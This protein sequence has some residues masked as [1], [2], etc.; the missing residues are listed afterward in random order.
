MSFLRSLRSPSEATSAIKQR[1]FGI[2]AW[3]QGLPYS[4]D[5]D[6]LKAVREGYER[7]VWVFRCVNAYAESWEWLRILQRQGRRDIGEEVNDPHDIVSLLNAF[8]NDYEEANIFRKRLTG[9]VLLSKKGAFV[10]LIPTRD[11]GG[12][13][14]NGIAGLHILPNEYTSVVPGSGGRFLD[15]FE[16]DIP[17]SRKVRLPPERVVWVRNG[18]PTDP[19]SSETPLQ[20]AGLAVDT[21]FLA[22]LYNRNFIRNDGRPGMILFVRGE[23]SDDDADELEA[24]ANGGV[25]GRISV[26]ESTVDGPD[27]T[28]PGGGVDVVELAKALS[29]MQYEGLWK[30]TKEEILAAHACPESVALGNASGRTF[31]NADAERLIWYRGPVRSHV[32]RVLA[33]FDRLD[34]DPRRFLAAD[35]STIP[36]IQEAELERRKVGLDELKGTGITRE[37][38]RTDYANRDPVPADGVYLVPANVLPT[39]AGAEP[40]AEAE[41]LMPVADEPLAEQVRAA[42][43]DRSED[44][45]LAPPPDDSSKDYVEFGP[46][47]VNPVHLQQAK[48]FADRRFRSWERHVLTQVKA[49]F[50]S[51]E[52]VVLEKLRSARTRRGTRH[53]EGKGDDHAGRG[54]K[55]LDPALVFDRDAWDSRLIE[56]GTAW[57]SAI[58]E[59]YGAAMI[60][61]LSDDEVV[62]ASAGHDIA[63]KDFDAGDPRVQAFLAERRNRLRSVNQTTWEAVRDAIIEGERAGETIDAIAARV[64]SVFTA[65]RTRASTIARTEVLSAANEGNLEGMRQSGVATE[66]VWLATSDDR[67]RDTHAS[68]D[69]QTVGVEE[70]FSVGG[71]EMMFPGDPSAPARETIACRCTLLAAVNGQVLL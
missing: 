67:T 66:K 15:G 52:R 68:A 26:I 33:P 28:I 36:E 25:A 29:D 61:R 71:V 35:F 59:D 38:Y 12:D 69:G 11:A 64:R 45:E 47:K 10:E 62:A 39:P 41:P 18:H 6:V 34:P 32:A 58:V 20:A 37:E 13:P 21:S 4:V 46:H 3:R 19:Y 8:P 27:G 48:S 60:E 2:P 57:A 5:W 22:A 17:G 50:A 54:D 16:I 51:Q 55:Q 42:V 24:R 1:V 9:Q 56:I 7:V 53:W 49:F 31:A 65:S 44:G 40:A 23:L 43:K 63:T 30:A 14:R 70:A